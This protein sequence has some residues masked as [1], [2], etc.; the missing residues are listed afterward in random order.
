MAGRRAVEEWDSFYRTHCQADV[1]ALAGDYPG[2]RSLY[3]DV[4]ELYEFDEAFTR[5]LFAEPDAML[6]AA[7]EALC[8]L[9]ESFDRVHVRPT[10]HPGLLELRSL[11]SRHVDELVSVEGTVTDVGPVRA[12]IR[13]ASFECDNCGDLTR[14]EQT[15]LRLDSPAGCA[16]CGESDSFR[17]RH[18]RSAIVDVQ[19]VELTDRSGT[20]RDD[21]TARPVPVVLDDDLVDTVERDTEQRV[22]G[23]VRLDGRADGNRFDLYVEALTAAE[24]PGGRRSEQERSAERA[25]KEMIESRW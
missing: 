25:L 10:N 20:R 19:R 9:H 21:R 23:L 12:A 3:V 16:T 5:R 17:L 2:E 11:R 14:R 18:G 7:T 15:G 6:D 1:D 4:F 22:T 8:A 13:T 24:A